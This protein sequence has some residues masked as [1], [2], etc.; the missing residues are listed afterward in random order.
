MLWRIGVDFRLGLFFS[1]FCLR[2][3]LNRSG[4]WIPC[5]GMTEV[6]VPHSPDVSDNDSSIAFSE[7]KQSPPK[8]KK[9]PWT[10]PE[11]GTATPTYN[12]HISYCLFQGL[13]VCLQTNF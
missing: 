12:V 2:F 11:K 10:K 9:N 8:D 13:W 4:C 5:A 6:L 1:V 7:K 3:L